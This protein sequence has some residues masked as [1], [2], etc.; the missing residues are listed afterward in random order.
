MRSSHDV[1]DETR[2]A[3]EIIS[4]LPAESVARLA[5]DDHDTICYAVQSSTMKLRSIILSRSSLRRLEGDPQ[6]AIKIEYL[7]RDLLRGA[8]RR[9]E[10]R[11]P[12]LAS[13][14]SRLR[15]RVAG[16]RVRALRAS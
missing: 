14:L 15:E 10:F 12:R 6:R 4:V 3:Q 1:K 2:I 13:A 9:A 11:Y 8:L 7:Q 16:G 5:S